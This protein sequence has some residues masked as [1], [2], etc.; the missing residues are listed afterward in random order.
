MINSRLVNAI[1]LCVAGLALLNLSGCS[2]EL[3][4]EQQ[5]NLISQA[6]IVAPAELVSLQDAT[7]GPPN[8]RRMWQFKI[9]Y[10]AKENALL[11]KGDL[12]VRFD[13]Q[14]LQNDLIGRKSQLQEA[15]KEAE[16]QGLKDEAA[17]Q[18]FILAV[19]EAKKNREIAQRKVE[20]TDTSRS[21]VERL[22]QQS[23]FEI[24]AELY[25]QAKQK[26]AQHEQAILVNKEVLNAK[27]ENRQA[28][29]RII[30]ESLEKLV[31]RAPKKGMVLYQNDWNGDKPAVGETVYMGRTLVSLPSLD[32]LAV[33]VEFDES[34][35][36]KV[37]VGQKV[38]VLLDAH[39]EKPFAGKI[40]S[41]GQAYRNKSQNNL[42]VVFDAW[43]ELDELSMDVMRPGMKAKVELL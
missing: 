21:E 43:V 8:V 37:A 40:T 1:T 26:L 25:L 15:I 35:T 20:I 33:K 22:K 30:E 3:T 34:D 38:K 41:L 36:A 19:A 14:R 13:G 31:I 2:N 23:E 16:K 27:I 32:K 6:R 10:L 12:V 4:Q 5:G 24:A 18:D 42:K 28:R 39:P 7:I 17:K 29:V 11:E 9:E